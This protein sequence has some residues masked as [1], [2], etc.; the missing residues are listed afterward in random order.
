MNMDS[1]LQFDVNYFE[2]P[3]A[4]LPIS[5]YL[6][7]ICVDYMQALTILICW[8]AGTRTKRENKIQ[9]KLCG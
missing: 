7:T 5:L 2:I 9:S 3:N 8:L 6:T 4:K 1:F